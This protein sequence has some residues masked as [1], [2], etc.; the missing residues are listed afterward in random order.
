MPIALSGHAASAQPDK[1][2]GQQRSIRQQRPTTLARPRRANG[3]GCDVRSR[4][5]A[6]R[7]RREKESPTSVIEEGFPSKV[8]NL[9]KSTRSSEMNLGRPFKAGVAQSNT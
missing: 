7:Y 1:H 4:R 6:E 5:P 8:Q 2:P 9:P 3:A